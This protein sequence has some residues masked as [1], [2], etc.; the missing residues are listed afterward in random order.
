VYW[1]G[2]LVV[3]EGAL[4]VPFALERG[5][6]VVG[7]WL[8]GGGGGGG[9]LLSSGVGS[10]VEEDGGSGSGVSDED[11]VGSGVGDE[12]GSGS[13][14]GDG[15]G[16]GSGVGED[17]GGGGGGGG[18]DGPSEGAS[19]ALLEIE[20]L[21]GRGGGGGG[22][23]EEDGGALD[24]TGVALLAGG[25]E[26]TGVILGLAEVGRG[27]LDGGGGGGGGLL[28]EDGVGVTWRCGVCVDVVREL[29]SRIVVAYD[30]NG[31]LCV[32]R[33]TE[34]PTSGSQA[35]LPIGRPSCSTTVDRLLRYDTTCGGT[36]E[37]LGIAVVGT[38]SGVQ[39][40]GDG[41]VR[42]SLSLEHDVDT[43]STLMCVYSSYAAYTVGNVLGMVS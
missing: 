40:V 21:L 17:E 19:A 1:S 20:E 16:S 15:V 13:G 27:V 28:D 26:G 39:F 23:R 41:S 14:G 8:G 29:I 3:D 24:G 25:L 7:T 43:G 11:G 22:T 42:V 6:V 37:G 34:V 4:I 36:N 2:R 35:P 10:G 32:P 38:I 5:V 31:T 12:E 30:C 9:A 33:L 18:D